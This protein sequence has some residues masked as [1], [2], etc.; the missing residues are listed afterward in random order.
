MIKVSGRFEI[1]VALLLLAGGVYVALVSAGYGTG[2]LKRLGPGLFPLWLG[3]GLAILAGI[4]AVG[5]FSERDRD[6]TIAARGLIWTLLGLLAF[7]LLLEFLGM[8]PATIAMVV[9]IGVGNAD[10][11]VRRDLLTSLGLA[12]FGYLLFARLLGIPVPL[13]AGWF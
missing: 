13:V 5:A 2:T 4:A 11:N 3:W 12:G 9:C 8:L 1:A 10:L 7:A 6:V